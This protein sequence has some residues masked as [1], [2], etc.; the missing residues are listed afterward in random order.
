MTVRFLNV[1]ILSNV[2][3]E[4]KIVPDKGEDIAELVALLPRFIGVLL[5]G[6]N[7][8]TAAKLNIS[9]EKTLM[10]IH[11]HEGCTMTEYSQRVGLARGSFTTVADSLE[12]KG[13]VGRVPDSDD[14]R[15]YAL[16]L[17]EEGQRVAREI[18]VQFKQHIAAR[19]ASLTKEDL[20]NLKQALEIIA[21]T[22][23][24]LKH[25]RN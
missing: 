3:L 8:Q 2:M 1:R 25:R 4:V 7:I 16:V 19:L 5:K 24:K 10:Y 23:E 13:L 14:R 21:A 15:K 18:D 6:S 17:T 9:E 12:E 20:S 22:A 11:K